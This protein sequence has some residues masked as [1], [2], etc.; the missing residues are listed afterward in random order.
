M[1]L[2]PQAWSSRCF[3]PREVGKWAVSL[4]NVGNLLETS[5]KTIPATPSQHITTLSAPTP[6]PVPDPCNDPNALSVPEQ[7]DNEPL[8]FLPAKIL[9]YDIE[10]LI[11]SGSTACHISYNVV[12]RLNLSTQPHKTPITISLADNSPTTS[13][14]YC[15]AKIKF[16]PNICHLLKLNVID[17]KFDLVLGKNWIKHAIPRP[18]IDWSSETVTINNICLPLTTRN[19][20]DTLNILSALQ[21]ARAVKKQ[22]SQPYLAIIRPPAIPDTTTTSI[23]H[24]NPDIEK[25]LRDYQDVFPNSLPKHLPPHRPVDHKIELV[26]GST[27]PAKRLYPLSLAEMEELKKQLQELLDQGFIRPSVSPYGAPV[28]FVKKKEG[29]MR[30]CVDYRALNKNTIKNTYPLPRIE[31]LLDQ[32]KDAKCFS[33]IDLRSGYHQVRI[34]EEDIHK[35]AFKTRYGL[36]EFLVMP[37]GL[38]NAPGTFMALMNETFRQELDSFVIIYLD[39]ILIY[40]KTPEEHLDH[41]KQVLNKLREHKLYAKLSKCDF[42]LKETPFLGHIITADGIRP[43]PAKIKAVQEWPTLKSVHDVQMFLGLVN[44]YR[45]FIKGYAKIAAPLTELLKKGNK[46]NWRDKERNAFNDLKKALVEAPTLAIFDPSLPVEVH[47]D[48][49]HYAAAAVL[50][51]NGRPIAFESRKLNSAELNYPVHEKEQLAIVYALTKWRIYLHSRPEPFTVFTDHESLKYLDTKK[52]Q[53]GRQARWLIDLAEFKYETKYK[54]GSLNVVPDALS[55]RPDLM[56]P[57][58][59]QLTAETPDQILEPADVASAETRTDKVEP[60]EIA[61]TETQVALAPDILHLCAESTSEDPQFKEIY[62]GVLD[63]DPAVIQDYYIDNGCLRLIENSRL[64]IPDNKALKHRLLQEVHDCPLSGHFGLEKTYS[65]LQDS[66]YWPGMKSTVQ[67]YVS[68][69]H[70][71]KTNK[72]RTTKENGLLKP[73]ETPTKPWT[74]IALDLVTHLPRSTKGNDALAVFVDRFSKFA[75][76]IPCKTSITAA[77]LANLFFDDVFRLF[78]IPVSLVSDRDPRF[79]SRF[80]KRLMEIVG[81]KMDMATAHHQQTDGQ[82]ERTIQTL[83]QYLRTYVDGSPSDWDTN[84]TQLEFAYNSSKSTSTGFSPFE[85]LYGDQPR[86]VLNT[87]LNQTVPNTD[88]AQEFI[89]NHQSKIQ[90]AH[91]AL[92]DA[93]ERMRTQYNRHHQHTSFEV[94]DLVY[95]DSE[96]L[97]APGKLKPKYLGPY[98]ILAKPGPLNYTLDLP[99]G[100]RVHNT[101]HVSKLRKHISRDDT[102]FPLPNQRPT[103]PPPPLVDIERRYYA[104]EYEVDRI[105]DHHVQQDGRTLYLVSWK[106]FDESTWQTLEDLENSPEA[107]H[108]YLGQATPGPSSSVRPYGTPLTGGVSELGSDSTAQTIEPAPQTIAPTPLTIEPT[109]RTKPSTADL[110]RR[111]RPRPP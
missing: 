1:L 69:C 54:K 92:L 64:C 61:A 66:V 63:E 84:L 21:F 71:C 24:D 22:K 86:T 16:A 105:L 95:V 33:K 31:E 56:S 60:A 35:T 104:D 48:A 43:D 52:K 90:M 94:G 58:Q 32:L 14:R 74:H 53:S 93:K 65:R 102:E 89:E 44:Y 47:V 88:T 68:S 39:D 17:I 57:D 103:P 46:W 101:F 37:F 67:K 6:Y 106:N 19:R 80:W 82:A 23:A 7:Y 41:L 12:K 30:M 107:L 76:I 29:D 59:E 3:L 2:L 4:D 110:L 51:Q 20:H 75:R 13:S 10:C 73:L 40:S 38:T 36:F 18:D 77:D 85:L 83:Q 78:G 108:E 70:T 15:I 91:D 8:S 25:I 28:L 98:K 99:P 62:Q 109:P 27:P 9:D 50:M 81:T 111:L 72:H 100:S 49:S 79:T 5:Q 34:A 87:A 11:D 45:R 55:R 26:Q 97:Q 96:N 42:A